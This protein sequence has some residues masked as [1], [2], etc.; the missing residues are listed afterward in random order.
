M[1]FFFK[2][3]LG[4]VSLAVVASFLY[5]SQVYGMD[6]NKSAYN[7]KRNNKR[8]N[9]RTVN[10]DGQVRAE[11]QY[12]LGC[13]YYKE[14]KYREAFAQFQTAANLNHTQAQHNLGAMYR[15]GEFVEQN[16]VEALKYF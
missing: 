16:D 12:K 6:E 9:K 10:P 13:K 11:V 8:P 14:K 2:R 3:N 5:T 4:L 15:A 7:T 1:T